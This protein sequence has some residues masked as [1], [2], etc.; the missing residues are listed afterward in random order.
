QRTV[1]AASH[2]VLTATD[3]A[4]LVSA[5]T[6]VMLSLTLIGAV[7]TGRHAG[8]RSV[9]VWNL[10][11][12]AVTVIL[13]VAA[14]ITTPVLMIVTMA[15]LCAWQLL[16]S[17]PEGSMLAVQARQPATHLEQSPNARREG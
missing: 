12:T 5:I 2:T 9:L 1:T 11:I 13:G 8:S 17:L 6:A 16:V 14:R 3:N 7:S 15:T 10:F 4:L